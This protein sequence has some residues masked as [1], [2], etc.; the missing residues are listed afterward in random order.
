MVFLSIKKYILGLELI[1]NRSKRSPIAAIKTVAIIVILHGCT[2]CWGDGISFDTGDISPTKLELS[3]SAKIGD[4]IFPDSWTAADG[5]CSKSNPT[6]IY[7][8]HSVITAR[9]YVSIIHVF[10]LNIVYGLLTRK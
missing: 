7:G 4:I 3:G 2:R 9:I 5:I 6:E 10:I 1:V 8:C